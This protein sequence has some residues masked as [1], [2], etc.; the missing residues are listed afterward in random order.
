MQAKII[1][2]LGPIGDIYKNPDVQ[3]I[4]VDGIDDIY[5][6]EDGRI[7]NANLGM[8]S[9]SEIGEIIKNVFALVGREIDGTVHTANCR[10]SDGTR[11]MAVLPPM[12]LN[13]PVFN[14]MKLP[15]RNLTWNEV[16]DYKS[17]SQEGI[18]EN[19]DFIKRCEADG[20]NQLKALFGLHASFTINDQTMEKA[21]AAAAPFKAGFH[22]HT[23]E[24][25]S[26]QEYNEEHFKL[27]VVERLKKYGMLGPK[28]IAVHCVHINEKEMELLAESG[29]AVVHNPQ[30]NLNNAVGIA[31]I[32]KMN[33]KG[34]LVGLGTDA[35]TVNMLEEVRAAMWAQHWGHKDPSCGFMEVCSALAFNN[36]K[37]ANRY[38]NPGVGVLKEGFAADII[39]M[40]YYPP[41]PFDG[42]T[43]LGHMVFGFSQSFVDTTIAGGKVLME[44]K[45]LCIDVDEEEAAAKSMELSEKLWERF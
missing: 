38:W 23:A 21:A 10:L 37:I 6:E 20:G 35:M 13:G 36:A 32:I 5:Y 33:E 34:V 28:S 25:A 30:S 45:K 12:S 41:T 44:N 4:I 26:D 16:L 42:N 9:E 11:F 40:D 19:I 39:L 22:V 2:A 17:I 24:A 3:E 31:D 29:T 18:D 27:R 7:I 1:E 15:K 43:F 14:L 8:K